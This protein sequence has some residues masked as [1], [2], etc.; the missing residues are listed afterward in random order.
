[1][2]LFKDGIGSGGPPERLAVFVVSGDEVVDALH[3][4]F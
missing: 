1:M 2:Q 4:L 3:E